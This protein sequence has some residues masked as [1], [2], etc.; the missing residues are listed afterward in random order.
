MLDR[1][2]RHS[3]FVE[4]IFAQENLKD[5]KGEP[6]EDLEEELLWKREK[7]MPGCEVGKVQHV[8]EG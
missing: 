7:K 6:S 3:L 1:M 5:V 2:V 8:L 4:R